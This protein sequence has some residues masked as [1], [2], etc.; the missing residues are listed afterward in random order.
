MKISIDNLFKLRHICFIISTML[1]YD[2]PKADKT[3]TND[4]RGIRIIRSLQKFWQNFLCHFYRI[5]ICPFCKFTSRMSFCRN[6]NSIL[7]TIFGKPIK[8]C[9]I[10]YYTINNSSIGAFVVK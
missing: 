7:C 8:L 3:I 4:I 1:V 2:C 9:S 5:H 6:P 10:C